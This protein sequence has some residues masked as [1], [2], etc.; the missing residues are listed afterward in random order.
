MSKAKSSSVFVALGPK[1]EKHVC[2]SWALTIAG[3]QHSCHVSTPDDAHAAVP[4][5]VLKSNALRKCHS[6]SIFVAL[7][8]KDG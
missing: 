3:L 4:R 8:L 7:G 5:Q 1:S 2:I 6:T